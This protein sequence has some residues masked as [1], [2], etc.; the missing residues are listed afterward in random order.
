MWGGFSSVFSF[1]SFGCFARFFSCFFWRFITRGVQKRDFKKSQKCFRSR[2]KK[3]L[4]ASF[5]VFPRAPLPLAQGA[6]KGKKK[7]KIFE[8]FGGKKAQIAVA[9]SFFFLRRSLL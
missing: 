5:F 9:F 2:Q 6:P 3:Y 7:S 1:F 4:L 8:I